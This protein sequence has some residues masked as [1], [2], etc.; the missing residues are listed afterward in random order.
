MN[1]NLDRRALSDQRRFRTLCRRVSSG[2][3]P[4]MFAVFVL[5]EPERRP[6]PPSP[7][8]RE[9]LG[10]ALYVGVLGQDLE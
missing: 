2:W 8:M 4:G 10:A 1:R 9:W 7:R 5:G 6:T 3:V